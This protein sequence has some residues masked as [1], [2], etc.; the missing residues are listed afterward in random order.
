VTLVSERHD[1]RVV[2]LT[3]GP[4]FIEKRRIDSAL[5]AKAEEAL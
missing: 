1:Q 4:L 3:V 2:P 5:L